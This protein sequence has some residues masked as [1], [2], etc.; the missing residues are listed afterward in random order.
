MSPYTPLQLYE[1]GPSWLE[2]IPP[3]I[4]GFLALSLV[5]TLL[6]FRGPGIA[7]WFGLL[8]QLF[9]AGVVLYV[10]YLLYRFVA[11]VERFV[12]DGRR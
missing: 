10:V 5:Y 8:Y 3:A 1:R 11:A 6:S 4:V 9:W 12:D 7:V 2:Y